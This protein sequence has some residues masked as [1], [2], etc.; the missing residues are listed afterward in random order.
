MEGFQ[1]F[2]RR[3]VTLIDSGQL[4]NN[5]VADPGELAQGFTA[6]HLIEKPV[7]EHHIRERAFFLLPNTGKPKSS[8]EKRVIA[9]VRARRNVKNTG[10]A[11]GHGHA[12]AHGHAHNR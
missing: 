1:E 8:S 12:H 11:N 10:Y 3:G 7:H 4:E 5:P 2:N 6:R 9:R